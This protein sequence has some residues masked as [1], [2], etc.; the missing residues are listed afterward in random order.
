MCRR[1]AVLLCPRT[2]M[3]SRPVCNHDG[4]EPPGHPVAAEA[5]PRAGVFSSGMLHR[6]R[7]WDHLQFCSVRSPKSFTL[8]KYNIFSDPTRTKVVHSGRGLETVGGVKSAEIRAG[9]RP[10]H[11]WR[12]P[13]GLPPC[14]GLT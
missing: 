6:N 9:C 11:R 13:L 7:E 1:V 5:S 3:L 12:R 10:A 2:G 8:C 4:V 14:L